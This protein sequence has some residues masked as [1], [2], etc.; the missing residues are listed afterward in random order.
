MSSPKL[1]IDFLNK[2]VQLL[3]NARSKV[4]QTVNQVMVITYFEVGRMIIE[5]EQNGKERAGYGKQLLKELSKVLSKEFG[6]G[7]SVDNLEI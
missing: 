3:Q 5:E 4:V 1:D 2:T 7:F 6:K